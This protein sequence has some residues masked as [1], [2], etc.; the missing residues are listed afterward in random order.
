MRTRMLR[1]ITRAQ[2]QVQSRIVR[3]AN[4]VS[5]VER[6]VHAE[7]PC[8][9]DI[10]QA[11]HQ[12][13]SA[14]RR[15]VEE[16]RAKM[17]MLMI[18]VRREFREKSE[19]RAATMSSSPMTDLSDSSSSSSSTSTKEEKMGS[20]NKNAVKSSSNPDDN[21]A[22]LS[23]RMDAERLKIESLEKLQKVWWDVEEMKFQGELDRKS[24]KGQNS[25]MIDFEGALRLSNRMIE[26]VNGLHDHEKFQECVNLSSIISERS[27]ETG[28]ILL[29]CVDRKKKIRASLK[30]LRHSG[31]VAKTQALKNTRKLLD[32]VQD[33]ASMQACL[34][35]DFLLRSSAFSQ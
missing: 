16:R 8:R 30:A 14:M 20:S 15:L 1:I 9:V 19:R 24:S 22:I 25:S 6:H 11:E 26:S 23:M 29:D 17:K 28:E 12:M 18:E 31:N 34:D 33:S 21:M 32:I 10:L 4:D 3:S 13:E 2:T 7:N 5:Y 27:L 35:E